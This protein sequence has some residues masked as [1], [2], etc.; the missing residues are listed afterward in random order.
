[1]GVLKPIIMVWDPL[2]LQVLLGF[3]ENSKFDL[4]KEC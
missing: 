3:R 4:Y 2:V 1:M